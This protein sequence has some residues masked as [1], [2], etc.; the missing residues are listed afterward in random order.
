MKFTKHTLKKVETLFKEV[1]YTVRYGKGNF[2]AGACILD[3]KDIVVVNK[4]FDTE[5]RINSLLDILNQIDYTVEDL[6]KPSQSL[7][8]KIQL[9]IKAAEE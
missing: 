4:F 9:E 3:G 8:S 1:G 6:S 2:Q 5:A 7:L